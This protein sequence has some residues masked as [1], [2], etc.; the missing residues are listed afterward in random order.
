MFWT[1][2]LTLFLMFFFVRLMFVLTAVV[3]LSIERKPTGVKAAFG[4]CVILTTLLY[5]WAATEIMLWVVS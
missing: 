2:F 4:F 1:I 3:K 5:T